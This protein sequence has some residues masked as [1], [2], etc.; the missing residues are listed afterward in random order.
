M[1]F[2]LKSNKN[3][4]VYR[5]RLEQCY[6]VSINRKKDEFNIEKNRE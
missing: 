6:I 4:T 1:F 5:I 2:Q 3:A